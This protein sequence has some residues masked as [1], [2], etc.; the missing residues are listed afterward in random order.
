[1][2]KGP[3]GHRIKVGG[4]TWIKLSKTKQDALIKASETSKVPVKKAPVKKTVKKA[5]VKKEVKKVPVKKTVK[6]VPVRKTVKKVEAPSTTVKNLPKVPK[7]KIPQKPCKSELE[8][9]VVFEKSKFHEASYWLLTGDFSDCTSLKVQSFKAGSHQK[10]IEHILKVANAESLLDL[11]QE[12]YSF[13]IARFL[14]GTKQGDMNLMLVFDTPESREVMKLLAR[15]GLEAKGKPVPAA[16]TPSKIPLPSPSGTP[17]KTPS[18]TP[19]PK[20][21]TPWYSP[22]K[23]PSPTEEEYPF[24]EYPAPFSPRKTPQS[25]RKSPSPKK[26]EGG[27]GIFGTIAGM[28]GATSRFLAGAPSSAPGSPTSPTGYGP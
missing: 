25:A 22:S 18:K 23:V 3:T 20:A 5:P 10:A 26:E 11:I 28:F 27:G 24:G 7:K 4:P 8:C 9:S 21:G 2:I 1:M 15:E 16:L 17:Y 6:K 12:D 13:W 14:A 19:V